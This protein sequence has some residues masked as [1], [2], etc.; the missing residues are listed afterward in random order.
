MDI[1]AKIDELV[2]K[3][4]GDDALQAEFKNDP[5]KALEKL[6]GKDL[7]DDKIDAVIDGIKAKLAAG[8]VAEKLGGL[9]DKFK[10]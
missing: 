4:K 2:D 6:T 10:K 9:F 3:I 7:P 8:D 1:K 5:V